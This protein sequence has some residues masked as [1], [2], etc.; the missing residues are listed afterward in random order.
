M[1][2]EISADVG[3]LQ[4]RPVEDTREIVPLRPAAVA[5]DGKIFLTSSPTPATCV[6]RRG[7]V[8]IP[9]IGYVFGAATAITCVPLPL[10]FFSNVVQDS[11][12][13]ASLPL[14]GLVPASWQLEYLV[15]VRPARRAVFCPSDSV[16]R[17]LCMRHA[18]PRAGS[19]L[20]RVHVG[21]CPRTWRGRTPR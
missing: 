18:R 17:L 16:R 2:F 13:G 11:V 10:F 12:S 20:R 19:A 6:F 15:R 3:N 9:R 4:R 8:P 1:P 7:V 21:M 5:S 14:C